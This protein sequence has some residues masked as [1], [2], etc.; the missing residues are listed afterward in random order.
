[1]KLTGGLISF[2]G[3]A[4]V[5]GAGPGG[6]EIHSSRAATNTSQTG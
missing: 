2:V 6:M 3:V 4:I 1:M 5:I